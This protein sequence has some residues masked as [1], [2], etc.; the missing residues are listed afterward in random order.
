MAPDA[1]KFYAYLYIRE[2]DSDGYSAG[3]PYYVGQGKKYRAWAKEPRRIPRPKDYSNILILYRDSQSKACAT[4]RELIANW[5]RLCNRTGCLHN[6]MTGGQRGFQGKHSAETKLH[7]SIS[8]K[9]QIPWNKG[10]TGLQTSYCK[11]KH[12]PAAHRAKLKAA[13][14]LRKEKFDKGTFPSMYARKD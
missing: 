5:G 13:W 2:K 7:W 9:G 11:G 12:L 14:I 1:T 6:R 3:T 4:E 8:R 10:K